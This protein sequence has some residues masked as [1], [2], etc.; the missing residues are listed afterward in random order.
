MIR[1]D[2]PVEIEITEEMIKSGQEALWRS[3]F[4]LEPESVILSRI[5]SAMRLFERTELRPEQ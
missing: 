4:S 1:E 2:R 5:Y 3:D